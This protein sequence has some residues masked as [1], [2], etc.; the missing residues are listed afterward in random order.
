MKKLVI[1]GTGTIAQVVHFYFTKDTDY[2]TVCF[3]EAKERL[4]SR[5][6]DGKPVIKIEELIADYK[7]DEY[8]VFIALGYRSH[9][10]I[11]AQRYNEIKDLGYSCPSYISS[12]AIYYDTEVGDNCLILENN[13]IQPFSEI[14]NNVFLWSGNHIGHHSKISNHCFISSHVVISG[15]CFI[16]EGAFLGVNSTLRD[17]I[18]VGKH[19]VLGAGSTL[20]TNCA[21]NEIVIPPKSEQK[22]LKRAIL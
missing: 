22:Q 13:V 7:P 18:T 20:M 19:S 21:D 16:G 11:R 6:F 4:K 9:N 2:Q 3:C 17:G 8:E 5:S 1:F 12:K 14:G 15:N 10:R